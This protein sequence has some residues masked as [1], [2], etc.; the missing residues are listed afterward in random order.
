VHSGRPVQEVIEHFKK[1]NVLVGRP[2]PPYTDYARISLG[3]PA[4]MEQFW[5]VWDLMPAKKLPA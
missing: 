2:F 3:T 1:N 4:D 5:R